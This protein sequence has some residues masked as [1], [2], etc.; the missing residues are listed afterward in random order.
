MS[1]NE[2]SPVR[3]P[4]GPCASL[5]RPIRLDQASLS[6]LRKRKSRA[7]CRL[8][9]LILPDKVARRIFPSTPPIPINA[10]SGSRTTRYLEASDVLH[11]HRV[12]S[13][14]KRTSYVPCL[15]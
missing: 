3:L 10:P 9:S 8:V 11:V 5:I 2:L 14:D 4:T 13:C 6:H 15:Q 12:S 7:L 1:A